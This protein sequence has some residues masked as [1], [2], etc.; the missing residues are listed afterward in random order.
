MVF[1][2]RVIRPLKLAFILLIFVTAYAFAFSDV[3]KPVK[4]AETLTTVY[5]SPEAVT[6]ISSVNFTIDVNVRFI[7]L[8][9]GYQIYLGWNPSLLEFVEVVES[10]F[11]SN[12]SM[13]DASFITKVTPA[14]GVLKVWGAQTPGNIGTAVG[15]NGTLFNVTFTAIGTGRSLLNLHETQLFL[16]TQTITHN[17]EDGL[18]DNKHHNAVWDDVTYP[19]VTESN[20]TVTAFNF[21]QGAKRVYFNVIGED[22]TTGYTNITIPKNLLDVDPLQPPYDW[23]IAVNLVNITGPPTS[24]DNGTHSF[25]YFTYTHSEH[26]IDVI[27]N[28]VIPEFPRFILPLILIALTMLIL[29][30]SK[31]YGS[32]RGASTV[33]LR[34]IN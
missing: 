1:K 30:T 3:A 16:G 17:V 19:V 25:V 26:R 20:S 9:N 10:P 7:Y 32:V 11:L 15:G 21:N 29:L 27:G 34:K 6:E 4:S 12:D 31:F 22:G 33:S 5:V 28:V 24:T 8:M 23:V 14:V 2:L 13:Y 18:F